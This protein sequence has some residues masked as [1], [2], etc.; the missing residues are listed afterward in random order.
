MADSLF[1]QDN[2]KKDITDHLE[3]ECAALKT[4]ANK[5]VKDLLYDNDDLLVYSNNNDDKIED[6][7]VFNINSD[8]ILS[9]TNL[10]GFI[11]INDVKI[12]I[13]SRFSE[14][15]G[16]QYFIQYMLQKIHKLNLFDYKTTHDNTN[17]WE[18]LL[19]LIFPVFLKRAYHQGIFKIYQKRHYNDSNVKGRIEI[20]RHIRE[21]LPF[22]GNIAY[23]NKEFSCNNRVTQLIRH[24]IEFISSKGYSGVYT[25]DYVA[26]NA[27]Q[28][29]K[30]VTPDYNISDRLKTI[31]QNRVRVNHPFFTEYEPLRKL[32]LQI[33]NNDGLS[34]NN[35]LNKVYGL[36]IDASWLWEEYLNTVLYNLGFIHP[37]NR[38]GRNKLKLFAKSQDIYPDFYDR[39]RKLVVEA[40]Y[41]KLQDA[42]KLNREDLYQ[43]ISYMYRL[44]AE[45]GVIL[46]PANSELVNTYE[47]NE[48]SYGGANAL[49]I[50]YSMNIPKE[51]SAYKEYTLRFLESEEGMK[52]FFE[53]ELMLIVDKKKMITENLTL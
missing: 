4:I 53:S 50:K 48:E 51:T 41:K 13:G 42:N 8:N 23:L 7:V 22:I 14:D 37:E 16:K 9:T 5:S 46:Y 19:Y 28:A 29:I 44:K 32:C 30:S 26:R 36:L 27:L 33:L 24:T 10:V 35:N 45:C 31:L 43:V 25:N 47:M 1:F 20:A 12:N 21:N 40:K 34:F 3:R 17:I 49:F 11:G 6:Q 38:T 2:S 39:K 52:N 18:Q 15:S